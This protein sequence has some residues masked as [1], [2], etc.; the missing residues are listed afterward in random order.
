MAKA[1]VSIG[2]RECIMD[3]KDACAVAEILSTAELY[4]TKYN[5][6]DGGNTHETLH[7]YPQDNSDMAHLSVKLIPDELYRM[8]K[9]AGKPKDE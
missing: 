7:A 9:L 2:Y 4:K 5:K 8:A 3:F 1:I 6:D